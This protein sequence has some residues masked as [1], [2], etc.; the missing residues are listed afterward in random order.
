MEFYL[1]VPL[2][3]N[4]VT[5]HHP[6]VGT[7]VVLV[8]GS[9]LDQRL[10]DGLLPHLGHRPRWIPDLR[11]H[12]N[13]TCAADYSWEHV[14]DDVVDLMRTIDR[15]VHMVG[16]SMGGMLAV[17]VALR[18]PALFSSMALIGTSVD[19][20]TQE[21][22]ARAQFFSAAI[23]EQGLQ[24]LAMQITALFLGQAAQQVTLVEAVA[25]QILSVSTEN[26]LR[27]IRAMIQRKDLRTR[28]PEITIPTLAIWGANDGIISAARCRDTAERF[29]RHVVLEVPEAGHLVGCEQPE[30]ISNE[31]LNLWALTDV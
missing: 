25:Q 29:V 12:G 31:L 21:T 19:G 30:L 24:A 2:K 9:L 7:P 16:V 13:S 3:Q 28:I 4:M 18:E 23:A 10:F 20:E 22:L 27:C 5:R 11:G 6:G 1:A 8:H 14:I 17:E 15:P 26:A